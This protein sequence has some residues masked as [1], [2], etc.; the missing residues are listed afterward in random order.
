MAEEKP[1]VVEVP[2]V[3]RNKVVLKVKKITISAVKIKA[4]GDREDLG[5]ISETEVKE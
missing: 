3:L 1:K 5:V 2:A 4:N